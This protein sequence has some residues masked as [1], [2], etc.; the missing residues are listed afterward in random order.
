VPQIKQKERTPYFPS[1]TSAKIEFCRA[2]HSI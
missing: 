2:E 1:T